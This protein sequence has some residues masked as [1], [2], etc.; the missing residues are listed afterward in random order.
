MPSKKYLPETGIPQVV[1]LMP[2]KRWMRGGFSPLLWGKRMVQLVLVILA[3]C[4]GFYT[5]QHQQRSIRKIGDI[6]IYVPAGD[7]SHIPIK[8]DKTDHGPAK[9]FKVYD[10]SDLPDAEAR[11]DTFDGE[12]GSPPP[13]KPFVADL[14]LKLIGTMVVAIPGKNVAFIEHSRSRV[15]ETVTEVDRAGNVR[16]KKILHD[17]IIVD[18][19]QG[20][21]QIALM[22]SPPA[23]IRQP[24]GRNKPTDALAAADGAQNAFK[25]DGSHPIYTNRPAGRSRFRH[26]DRQ[27]VEQS[28]ADPERIRRQVE[29]K[30]VE[31]YGQ[32]AGFR[33]ASIQASSI[34]A[35]LGLR[36]TDVIVGINGAAI[37][38]PDQ[39]DLLFQSIEA[40][41]D[42][43]IQVK[44]KRR[45]RIIHLDIS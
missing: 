21:L 6:A 32:P 29:I 36:S 23:D 41:G 12:K 15:R 25:T 18:D 14:D 7:D 26:F 35:E 30:P 42:V 13:G 28:L 8:T 33:V 44:G 16:V 5:A 37:T 11:I 27:L 20:E 3:V 17:R 2:Q 31:T 9:F 1:W 22:R 4:T 40:G 43:T 10:K 34:F 39:A 19:G 24:T 38:T 45:N